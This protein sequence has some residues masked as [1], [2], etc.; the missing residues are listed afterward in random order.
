[1]LVPPLFS[2]VRNAN[3]PLALRT[4]CLSLLADC[5]DTY[6]LAMLPYMEDL[7]QAMVDLLQVEHV[8]SQEPTRKTEAAAQGEKAGMETEPHKDNRPTLGADPTS[9]D[10]KIPPLRRAAIHFLS[11]LIRAT[12]KLVYEESTINPAGI[13]DRGSFRRLSVT[14]G[15]ISSTD[16]DNL[17]RIMARE[18]KENLQELQKAALGLSDGN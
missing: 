7:S 5:V 18:T 13:Y 15:Y 4:S 12:T 17:V 11:L 6:P 14:L 2:V 8:P 10:S 16:E 3:V 1:M 9:K